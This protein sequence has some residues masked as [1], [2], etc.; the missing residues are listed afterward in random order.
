MKKEI[1]FLILIICLLLFFYFIHKK[2]NTNL[3]SFTNLKNNNISLEE[4]NQL[5]NYIN[6]KPFIW[7][8]LEREYNSKKWTT[9]GS[10]LNL[11]N[12]ESYSILCLYTIYKHCHQNF[13]IV[14]LNNENINYYLHN[15][16]V[17]MGP[18]STIPLDRR[19]DL[20]KFKFLYEYGGIWMDPHTIV[21]KDLLPTYNLLNQFE[22]IVFGCPSDYYLCNKGY[23][24]PQTK[25]IMSLPKLQINNLTYQH[26]EKKITSYN[27]PAYEFAETGDCIFWKYL[28][29]LS[30]GKQLKFLHL[31]SEFNGTRD[32]NHKLIGINNWL[33][34]NRTYFI[35][36]DKLLFVS[37][38][39]QEINQNKV[40]KWF[41]RFSFYQIINSDL[42]ISYLFKKSLGLKEKYY[43]T[44]D[45]RDTNIDEESIDAPPINIDE[46][47][48]IFYLSN[49]FATQPWEVVYQQ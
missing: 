10:R 43:Y 31:S 44:N 15:F 3:D 5:I 36:E 46:L 33:S 26:I 9:F 28:E 29:Q 24:K 21:M 23:M 2:K 38:D 37:L 1:I 11:N 47:N 49:Y 16:N 17:A 18:N 34:T 35:D 25:V 13:N 45:Y 19:I 41:L 27:Y 39:N 22:M 30:F 12:M 20:I 32:F 14:F 42:W 40:F 6:N 48:R 4:K 8:Y 7:I